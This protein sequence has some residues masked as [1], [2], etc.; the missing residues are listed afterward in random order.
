MMVPETIAFYMSKFAARD[1]RIILID[2]KTKEC[3]QHEML[4]FCTS[5]DYIYLVDSDDYI[6]CDM[7]GIDNVRILLNTAITRMSEDYVN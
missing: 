1:D 7:Y 5:E 4:A 6:S 2:K 3:L